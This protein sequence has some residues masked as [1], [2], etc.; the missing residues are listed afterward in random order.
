MKLI[1]V[2]DALCA[3]CYGYTPVMLQLQEQ[4]AGE[5]EFEILSGGMLLDENHRPASIL[6]N[7]MKSTHK[8][9]Q[10]T[11]GVIFGT[12][13]LEEYLQTE[14]IMDS[15]KPGIALTVFKEYQ[16]EKAISF[17]HDMQ[18]ALNYDGKSLNDDKTYIEILEKYKISAPEF[19]DKMKQDKYREETQ[20]EFDQVKEWDIVG[21][22]VV[23]MDDGEKLHLVGRGFMPKDRM[24]HAIDI[25]KN[26]Q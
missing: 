1:Y 4:F 23:I 15:G 13:F 5:I 12:A 10:E 3:W 18:V 20:E 6:Y 25:L 7:Y 24:L 9:V 2:Y 14:D 26:R 11:A 22:P 17:A 21:F 16:P 19:L 8:Q